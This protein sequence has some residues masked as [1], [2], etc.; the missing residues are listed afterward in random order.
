MAV[1]IAIQMIETS[2]L[3]RYLI[4]NIEK[5]KMIGGMAASGEGRTTEVGQLIL[6]KKHTHTHMDKG[7][8]KVT[9]NIPVRCPFA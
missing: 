5:N 2:P 1:L 6:K 8:H 3:P 4:N 7:L 9:L